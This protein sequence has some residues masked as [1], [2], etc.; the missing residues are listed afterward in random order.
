MSALLHPANPAEA[1]RTRK[2]AVARLRKLLE[3]APSLSPRLKRV[4]SI[5]RQVRA[6][7][8]H[9]TN[10]CNLRCKGCWFFA[11]DF[12]HGSKEEKSLA[13]WQRFAKRE[14]ERGIT[15]PLLIGGEPTLVLDR[16]AA[17]AAEMPFVTLSTN[18]VRPV[19]VEGLEK[20]GVAI[21]MFG[22]SGLD[23]ELRGVSPSGRPLTGLFE[24]ALSHYR[25]DKR[26]C[27]IV[28]L[29]PESTAVLEDTAVRIEDNGNRLSF[30]Y[31]SPHGESVRE[32]DDDKRLLDVAL[33]VRDR[34]P[35][36]VTSHPYFIK[37]LITGK[38]HF[39]SFGYD[40]CPSISVDHEAHAQ[41][42]RNGSPH[43]P[44]FN[45]Y[46]ADAETINFCCTSGRCDSCRD[47]QAV[48]SWLLGSLPEFLGSVSDLEGWIE[49]A[50]DYWRQ[51]PWWMESSALDNA[52]G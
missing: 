20:I 43:L 21:T 38:S 3:R 17:F 51:F 26:V 45:S 24:A 18:G 8:Y 48:Y 16:V 34:H 28:A 15:A 44:L 2:G 22:G 23:D 27:F 32:A 52:T 9:L 46:A 4:R 31:Y 49:L 40:V 36:A 33:A 42:K 37:T 30:N 5:A 10:A 35:E 41:R 6:S 1:P 39:G 14:H 7:E 47:S 13:A 11:Y 12:D 19:P 25:L 29:T 50:E